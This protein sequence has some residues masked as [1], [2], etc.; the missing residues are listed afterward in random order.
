MKIVQ[1]ERTR[2]TP[3]LTSFIPCFFTKHGSYHNKLDGSGNAAYPNTT[4]FVPTG[5]K[6]GRGRDRDGEREGGKGE[7]GREGG[8]RERRGGVK[9]E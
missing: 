3:G 9:R 8:F 6:G 7:G 4:V 2:I 1:H 5:R